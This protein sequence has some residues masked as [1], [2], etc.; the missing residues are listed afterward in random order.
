MMV[1]QG[2]DLTGKVVIVTG[3]ASL[4]G[5]GF[6]TARVLGRAGARVVLS[7]LP[8]STLSDAVRALLCE[9]LDV[10]QFAADISNEEDVK[11]LMAFTQQ[12][13]GRLDALDNNAAIQE[14]HQD[15]LLCEMSASFWDKVFGVNARGTM[16]MCKHAIPLMIGGGGGSIINISSGTAR[17]GDF[18]AT[19]Y[20]ASKGAINTLT[21]YVAVQY[22]S[23]GIRC[24]AIAPGLIAT[25][26]VTR[27][28]PEAIR[29]VFTAHSLTGRLGEPEDIGEMVAFLVSSRSKFITGQIVAVDG[30]I[31]AHI[32][33][34][35]EVAALTPPA[36][37]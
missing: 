32:P 14:H 9:G 8:A 22:G 27:L 35:V 3:A 18:F 29:A 21:K 31:Y 11:A 37:T 4:G 24:N 10:V 34:T 20:A 26:T 19:A 15:L 12:T 5:I 17:A 6:A 28:L 13:F 16:L 1:A 36:G 33:T 30:G 23:K 2:E 7:D 25:S